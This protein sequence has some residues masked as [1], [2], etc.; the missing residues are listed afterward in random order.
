MSLENKVIRKLKSIYD[1]EIPVDIY[2][3]GL[4]YN[5]SFE[6][7]SKGYYC[8]ILMTF[9]SP[10]CPVADFLIDSVTRSIQNIDK[11]YKVELRIT[12]DPP[13]DN[14]KIS[15]EGREIF[16]MENVNV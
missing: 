15:E 11:I 13:W 16:A 1:P 3:L 12:F 10:N 6:K 9:T 14:S 8:N 4:I 7:C 2:N 5:I